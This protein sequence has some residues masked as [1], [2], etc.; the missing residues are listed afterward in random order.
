MKKTKDIENFFRVINFDYPEWIP[1]VV[2]LPPATWFKYGQDLETIVLS[3]PVLFPNYIKGDFEHIELTRGYQLGRWVDVFGTV[4]DNVEEGA[5]D[6][7]TYEAIA[8]R[9]PPIGT[10]VTVLF[11]R[12]VLEAHTFP[13]LKL[14]QEVLDA[15]KE[16]DEKRK[17]EAKEAE[18]K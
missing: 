8:A 17:R 6:N 16:R 5:H 14:P 9:I 3:H 13:P 10:R 4:W 18:K 1:V 11:S 7:G 12:K 2:G 15:R